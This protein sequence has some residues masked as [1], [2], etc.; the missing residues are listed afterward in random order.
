MTFGECLGMIAPYY[1]I[2]LVII[3]IAL[4]IRLFRASTKNKFIKPWIFIFIAL[5]IFVVETLFT[6]MRSIGLFNLPRIINPLFE[7]IIITSFIYMVL[8]QKEYIKKLK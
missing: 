5:M 8:I 7:M 4:F 3:V 2:A 6:I 1:N